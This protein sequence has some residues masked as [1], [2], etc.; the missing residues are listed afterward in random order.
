MKYFVVEPEVAGGFGEKTV[1]DR[2]T[3]TMTVIA[4]HYEFDGWLG[5]ELLETAPCFIATENLADKI[6]ES[7]LLGAEAGVVEVSKSKEFQRADPAV[8]LPKFVWLKINGRAGIDDF[9]IAPDYS[10]VVSEAALNILK[11]GAINH[12]ASVREI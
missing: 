4:L 10:L 7:K 3:G 5:D 9:G 12:A 2:S 1:I 6:S 8:V 11:E